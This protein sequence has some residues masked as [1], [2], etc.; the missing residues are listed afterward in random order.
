MCLEAQFGGVIVVHFAPVLKKL[1]VMIIGP[2][3]AVGRCRLAVSV[4]TLQ[5]LMFS[6]TQGVHG[7]RPLDGAVLRSRR[8]GGR[9]GG[10]VAR[11]RAPR[12]AGGA[13]PLPAGGRHPRRG[14]R[15]LRPARCV[16]SARCTASRPRREN[17]TPG[18]A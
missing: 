11:A 3:P 8:A 15:A 14:V 17:T 6:R 5:L 16:A 1:E 4:R 12:A 9:G 18:T 7:A 13:A 2:H 10:A